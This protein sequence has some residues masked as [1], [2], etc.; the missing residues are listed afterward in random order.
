M[1]TK[2]TQPI[3]GLGAFGAESLRRPLFWL[4]RMYRCRS[5]MCI[6]L[7][8]FAPLRLG[9]SFRSDKRTPGPG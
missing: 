4:T 3:A 9:V 6:A 2:T 8:F 5:R 1:R 7:P